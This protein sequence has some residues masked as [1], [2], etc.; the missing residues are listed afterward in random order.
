M[1][2]QR[3]RAISLRAPQKVAGDVRAMMVGG[4]RRGWAGHKGAPGAR[5]RTT[6]ALTS[7]P[8][9]QEHSM[10]L[11][12][13]LRDVVFLL[14]ACLLCGGLVSRLGQSPLIGYLVAGMILGGPGSLGI[15]ET[16]HEIE[17]IA[18]LGVALLLFSLGLEFSVQRL[19][20]LGARPLLGGV[21][22]VLLTLFVG[23][24]VVLPLGVGGKAAI[25]FGA[26]ISLSSTAVVLRMLMERSELDLPHGRNCLAVLLTQDMA[27]VPLA[28][29]MSILGGSGGVGQMATEAGALLGY[30]VGLVA[31]LLVVNQLAVLSL[32][33]LTLQRNREL[34]VIFAVATGLGAAWAAHWVGVSPALGAFVA[35]MLLG[36]SA[37]ATQI[38]ADISSLRVL[39]LT[40]FFGA[41]GMVADPRWMLQNGLLVMATTAAILIGKMLIIWGIFRWLGQ[42]TRVASA[43]GV[44]LAQIGEFAFVLGT[45]GKANSVVTDELYA[46][47][48]STAIF[49]FILSAFLVPAAPR[50]GS[51]I[52]RRFSTESQLD[53][54]EVGVAEAVDVVIVGFGPT[55]E[56]IGEVLLDR[57]LQVM[58][59]DLNRQGVHKATQKGLAAQVGDAM[60]L[61]V[62]EHAGISQA[63]IVAVTVP[64]FQSAM[65]ILDNVRQ[66]APQ[67][68]LFARSRYK[69][70]SDDFAERGIVVVGDEEEVGKSLAEKVL[71]SVSKWTQDA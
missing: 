29:L 62:L 35:G 20:R 23:T 57:G 7:G 3:L 52:A 67:A 66:L 5:G 65:T 16:Q 58:V 51:W 55:G 36:S 49:S 25:A 8:Q 47:V 9:D 10:E 14:T 24:M 12:L 53:G 37:F 64:H 28:L 59:I 48:V 69:L 54:A 19:R 70:H 34:T 30:S 6:S 32:G 22:Q 50:V 44:C 27:V 1:K 56:A 31:V 68:T 21:L 46:L 39:L 2:P 15:I 11:W 71:E 41:A 38:R 13:I 60:Q 4:N 42:S 63:K 43:T 61:E 17:A 40:L 18:E 26:M 45:I 33:T